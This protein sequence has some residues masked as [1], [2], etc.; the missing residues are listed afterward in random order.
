MKK[1]I[2]ALAL[3]AS[4]SVMAS[5]EV[6]QFKSSIKL[7]VIA[8]SAK[9]G[10]YRNY[11]TTTMNGTLTV[12]ADSTNDVAVIDAIIK[13]TGENVRI[14][15][16]DEIVAVLAGKKQ[17]V[18]AV[19]FNGKDENDVIQIAG[20]GLGSTKVK[21]TGCGPCGDS[22]TC[23][24]VVKVNGNFVGTYD[25]G[26]DNPQFATID[27]DCEV[28]YELDTTVAPVYGTWSIALKTVDGLKYK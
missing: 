13:K 20:A 23:T 15:L 1:I 17:N 22:S 24:H 11:V 6:Y 5:V 7:P 18:A 16:D 19:H 25:C 26:C 10:Y 21:I 9:A 4:M 12:D 3:I 28:D 2:M 8:G 27:S 14:V